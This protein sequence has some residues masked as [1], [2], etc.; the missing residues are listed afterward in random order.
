MAIILVTF[1]EF[2]G[3]LGC[4]ISK[5]GTMQETRLEPQLCG[6]RGFVFV[7][8]LS[9]VNRGG[10]FWGALCLV[11]APAVCSGVRWCDIPDLSSC[12]SHAWDP[13]AALFGDKGRRLMLLRQFVTVQP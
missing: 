3:R 9:C 4:Y 11:P 8:P 12:I 1:H 2:L 13:I 6:P 10:V 5:Y 7:S